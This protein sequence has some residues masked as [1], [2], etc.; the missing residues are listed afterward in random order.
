MLAGIGGEVVGLCLSVTAE[1]ATESLVS[2]G[3]IVDRA[4]PSVAD[5]L[6]RLAA[7]AEACEHTYHQIVQAVRPRGLPRLP[8]S[9]LCAS[10]T[11]MA[12]TRDHR[13]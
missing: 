6:G 5:V 2:Y 3:T 13:S 12:T 4:E 8:R 9:I 10:P 1:L 11:D 7:L